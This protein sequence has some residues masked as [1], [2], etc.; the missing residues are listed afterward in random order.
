MNLVSYS[1]YSDKMAD[2]I[3]TIDEIDAYTLPIALRKLAGATD[4]NNQ[5]I[6]TELG[7]IQN[8]ID[9]MED[10]SQDVA[11]LKQQMVTV[12]A[13]LTTI[14]Q[15]NS[16]QDTA[17]QNN[18]NAITAEVTA[19]E[20][21]DITDAGL[22]IS[23]GKIELQ[24]LRAE[25]D[26][27]AEVTCPFIQTATLLS[28]ATDR[29]F[30]IR[31]TFMDGTEY[32]TNDFVIPAGGGTDVTVTGVT[33][34]NGT[35]PNSFKV[36]IV[37]SDG[38]QIDSN[39]Y[40]VD[41][42]ASPYPTGMAGTVNSDGSQMTI[43]LTL[44]NST[45]V[46]ANVDLSALATQSALS[47]LQEQ[48]TD[49]TITTENNNLTLNGTTV[50]M[51]KSAT[52]SV[53]GNNLTINVNGVVSTATPVITSVSGS[54][55][56]G[57]LKITVNGVTS[58]DIPL[59]ESGFS[60]VKINVKNNASFITDYNLNPGSRSRT[61]NIQDSNIKEEKVIASP[62]IRTDYNVVVTADI[63]VG[64]NTSFV[65][66]YYGTS[67]LFDDIIE[68]ALDLSNVPLSNF[69]TNNEVDKLALVGSLY[70]NGSYNA[71]ILFLAGVFYQ[72][73][74]DANS[75][76]TESKTVYLTSNLSF[77]SGTTIEISNLKLTSVTI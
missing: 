17:I 22:S 21:N 19:R 75:S 33:V 56:D 31:F 77:T 60:S 48:L 18:E 30:K 64:T 12:E 55:S 50:Q 4:K 58:G 10:V 20:N 61:A 26:F 53:S 59:P 15:K 11:T 68:N 42:E 63:G 54:V 37:L 45:Q 69:Y 62:P 32:D 6:N 7:N 65:T 43:T 13:D 9:S 40:N 47:D 29:A 67:R 16:E 34:S 44:S 39:D 27:E 76:L 25:G 49:L 3:S 70:Y 5:A 36:S 46:T 57:N 51:V 41:I 24:L 73:G 74:F 66:N 2:I 35:A 71:F 8:E 14:E 1:Y 23:N 52:A 38:T 28:T 72:N